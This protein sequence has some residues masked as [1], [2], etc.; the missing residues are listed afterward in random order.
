MARDRVI[1]D[2][3]HHHPLMLVVDVDQRPYRYRCRGC[4]EIG[5]GPRYACVEEDCDYVLHQPCANPDRTIA[6]PF[7]PRCSFSFFDVPK[8]RRRCDAC[9]GDVKGFVYHCAN[10]GWDL[11]PCCA[12][13]ERQV[14]EDDV[15]FDLREREIAKCYSCGKRKLNK[16][17]KSWTYVSKC[18][19]YHFHVSCMK[20]GAVEAVEAM[21]EGTHHGEGGAASTASF[22]VTESRA[23]QERL[24]NYSIARRKDKKKMRKF[25][26]LKTIVKIA[27]GIMAALLGDPT[28]LTIA[29]ITS[30]ISN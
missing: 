7:F 21:E 23:L 13:L 9:G 15:V 5:C 30:L 17:A 14:K 19:E 22:K 4:L 1:Q 25:A 27:V 12:K 18:G 6:H 10:K 16:E 29:L 20:K 28:T 26:M 8:P 3:H 24:P 11:H 2:D